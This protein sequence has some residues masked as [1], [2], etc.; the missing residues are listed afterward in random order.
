[1][2]IASFRPKV[3]RGSGALLALAAATLLAGC[4]SE[5]NGD[6]I[7]MYHMARDSWERSG[8]PV[9]L[10]EA[11]A[12]PYATMGIRIGGDM[13]QILV[14]ATE[15]GSRRLWTSAAKIAIVTRDGRI[16]AVAGLQYNLAGHAAPANAKVDWKVRRHY[17]WIADFADLGAYSV[18]I[19]CDDVP[20]EP[21][22]IVIL[23]QGIDTLRVEE[24]CRSELLDWSFTN[25]YW[26]SR[27]SNRVWRSIQYVH[28]KLDALEFELL[29]PPVGDD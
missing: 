23:G 28:P 7:A 20:Q 16:E 24:N 15:N 4:S 1:M 9:Q 22:Q 29:R 25:T 18:K 8:G 11:S 14:L 26:V 21:E 2:S 3:R 19:E 13:E 6:W 5:G 10:E 12:I 17:V 27:I